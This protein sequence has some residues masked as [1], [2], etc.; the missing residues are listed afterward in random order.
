MITPFWMK[1][2]NDFSQI[3]IFLLIIT[4]AIPRVKIKRKMVMIEKL[5]VYFIQNGESN[6]TTFTLPLT[7]PSDAIVFLE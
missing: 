2:T 5:L 4:S 6:P 1:L 3:Y 7:S